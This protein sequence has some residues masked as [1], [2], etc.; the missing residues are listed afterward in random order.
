MTMTLDRRTLLAQLMAAAAG[1]PVALAETP[2]TATPSQTA[3]PFYPD[4][5]PLDRDADLT[6][7]RGSRAAAAGRVVYLSGRILDTRG[8]PVEGARIE[9]WQANA[10][11]RYAHPWD[12][13]R[14]PLDPNFQGYGLQVTDA[15]GC[16]RFKTIKPGPYDSRPPHIHVD[17]G[18]PS[19]DLT[20]QIYF[21]GEPLNERDGIF[22][23][24]RN[25]EALI[26]KPVEPRGAV[27]DGALVLRWDAVIRV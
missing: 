6:Q 14:R 13:S 19:A 8:R 1:V 7:L 24:T 12:S 20:T 17:I 5:K 26:A 16:Y 21:P 15:Q 25:R 2:L 3:G 22:R 4:E 9:I 18:V 23:S 11:G 10:H 27:E